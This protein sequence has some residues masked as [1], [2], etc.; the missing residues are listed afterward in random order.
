[1]RLI[2]L[3]PMQVYFSVPAVDAEIT[4]AARWTW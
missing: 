4:G 3:A 1:M 2:V